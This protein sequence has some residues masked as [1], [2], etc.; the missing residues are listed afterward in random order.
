MPSF[1]E[2]GNDKDDDEP[3]KSVKETK[4]I[5]KEESKQKVS[6]CNKVNYA[7]LRRSGGILLCMLVGP[8]V[9][10]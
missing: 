4:P 9:G 5:T 1:S 3:D 7:P 6:L 10:L 8:L 2:N